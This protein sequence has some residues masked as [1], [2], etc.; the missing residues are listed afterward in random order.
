MTD[1]E[2]SDILKMDEIST[3]FLIDE[4]GAFMFRM[5]HDMGHG[6]I[7]SESHSAIQKDIDNVRIIQKFAVDNLMR[8]GVDPETANDRDNGDYWKWYKF[9]DNWKKEMSDDQWNKVNSLLAKGESIEEYLP[10]GS[11][12]NK[13]IKLDDGNDA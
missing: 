9:W 10:F 5:S 13:R 4:C 8:F 6:R 1:Q 11:W 3:Y 7:P 12:K 2:K